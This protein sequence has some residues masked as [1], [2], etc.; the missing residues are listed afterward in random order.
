MV[1]EHVSLVPEGGRV[2]PNMTVMDNLRMGAFSCRDNLKNGVLDEM[3]ELFPIL[4]RSSQ[5]ARTLSGGE[6]QML[7][8]A[9]AW[10]HG[11]GC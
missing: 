4:A 3:Y 6:R 8:I 9:A 11:R 7:A 10:S 1:R 5:Y 2:F